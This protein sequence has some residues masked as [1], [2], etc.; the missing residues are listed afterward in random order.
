MDDVVKQVRI[1][2]Q[3]ERVWQALTDAGTIAEWMLDPSAAL[4]LRAGGEYRLFG[5]ETSGQFT[6]IEKPRLLEYTWRQSAWPA[7][8][9]DSRV[10]WQLSAEG[11][12]TQV[13]LTHSQFPNDDERAGH[14]SGWDDYWLEPMIDYLERG[15]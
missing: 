13:T 14:D 12:A 9:A 15:S 3:I 6:A 1:D 8:W 10:R 7:E 2:A 4:D 5:G 11:G